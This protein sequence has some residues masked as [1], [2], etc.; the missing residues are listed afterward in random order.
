LTNFD[1][2]EELGKLLKEE[3]L[4]EKIGEKEIEEIN[5]GDS[6]PLFLNPYPLKSKAIYLKRQNQFKDFLKENKILVENEEAY[7]KYFLHLQKNSNYKAST[8][9]CIFGILNCRA[10][11]LFNINLTC[12]ARLVMFLRSLQKEHLYKKATTFSIRDLIRIY[13]ID[14]DTSILLPKVFLFLFFIHY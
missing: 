2:D 5:K 13:S 3:N 9:W 6:L 1:K 11:I 4:D 12:Y 8:L 7:L 10:K 14:D